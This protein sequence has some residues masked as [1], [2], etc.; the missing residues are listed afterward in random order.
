M[1]KRATFSLNETTLRKLDRISK[2][3]NRKKSTVVDMAIQQLYDQ[4]QKQRSHAS[5]L[6]TATNS[7]PNSNQE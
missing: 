5:E 7:K 6:E 1:P 4:E 2:V 3:T